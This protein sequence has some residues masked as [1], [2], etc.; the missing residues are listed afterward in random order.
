MV[1]VCSCIDFRF[2]KFIGQ[3]VN[4]NGWEQ[5]H[6]RI[7]I[8]GCTKDIGLFKNEIDISMRL[9]HPQKIILLHHEDCGA[10]GGSKNFPSF[11][12]ELEANRQSMSQAKTKI[13]GKYPD[14]IIEGYFTLISGENQKANI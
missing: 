13:Q 2:Q 11:E 12:G 9:H 5:K 1:T 14:I 4:E 6:D 10:Y 8:A 3:F 7:S